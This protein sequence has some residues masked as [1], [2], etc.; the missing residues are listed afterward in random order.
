MISH[1]DE[2]H[3]VFSLSESLARGLVARL[4]FEWD[5][6]YNCYMDSKKTFGR[7]G[8][9]RLPGKRALGYRVLCERTKGLVPPGQ[10]VL[11]TCHGKQDGL[12]K[13][14]GYAVI[15]WYAQ[16]QMQHMDLLMT[17]VRPGW[18]FPRR[19]GLL[20][21]SA[22]ALRRL[23]FRLKTLDHQV[24]L[25][26]LEPAVRTICIWFPLLMGLIEV[27]E[28]APSIGIPT[29]HGILYLKRSD[30]T[31]PHSPGDL[32]AATW[33]SDERMVDRPLKLHAVT[34]ARL[35]GGIVLQVGYDSLSVTPQRN[36]HLLAGRLSTFANPYFKD[37]LRHLPIH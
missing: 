12:D 2:V 10:I 29:P 32:I 13:T 37:M 7:R 1:V 16:A 8:I 36:L 26:E 9:P 31:F 25:T 30:Q 19:W 11:E 23:F 18:R 17:Y 6:Q 24:I 4:V 20:Q 28:V 5:E 21:M 35:E 3:S 34:T 15:H 22:H 14:A 33:I 27:A